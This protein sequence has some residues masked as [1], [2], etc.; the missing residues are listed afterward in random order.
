MM[1]MEMLQRLAAH[2]HAIREGLKTIQGFC[3][4]GCLDPAA[5]RKSRLE[6]TE[7]SRERS[8][9]ISEVIVPNLLEIADNKDRAELSDLLVAVTSRRLLSDRHIATWTDERIASDVAGY[10]EAA[11]TI[12][13]M[14]ED[15]IARETRVLGSQLQRNHR[16]A[17]TPR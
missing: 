10:C 1:Q 9:Y 4:A 16:L 3:E 15:Q 2:H 6:L 8:H 7:A 13:S 17:A 5:L 12:W 11:R 14:M